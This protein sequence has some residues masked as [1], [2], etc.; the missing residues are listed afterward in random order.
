MALKKS[1]PFVP[2]NES[3]VVKQVVEEQVSAKKAMS[4][5][6]DDGFVISR[7]NAAPNK[8]P[9]QENKAPLVKKEPKKA[10]QKDQSKKSST[11]QQV[12]MVKE[13]EKI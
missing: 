7:F 3:P 13:E 4:A 10:D 12:S 1:Q 6:E 2:K 11:K 5:L 8:P 9:K